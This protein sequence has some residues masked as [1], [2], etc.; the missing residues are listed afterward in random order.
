MYVFDTEILRL[1]F[2]NSRPHINH[3]LTPA[4]LKPTFHYAID[5]YLLRILNNNYITALSPV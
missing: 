2:R 5:K 3:D 4:D 1:I